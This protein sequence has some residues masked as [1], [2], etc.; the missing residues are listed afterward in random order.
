M[1][2]PVVD[3]DGAP[4]W[5][6]AAQRRTPRPGLRRLRRTPLPAPPLLPALPV[7]RTASGA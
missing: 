3:D 7:L 1:L 2:T 4:F 6:Y 5:E